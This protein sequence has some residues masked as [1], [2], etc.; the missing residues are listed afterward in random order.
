M[1]SVHNQSEAADEYNESPNETSLL[2]NSAYRSSKGGQSSMILPKR[3][4]SVRQPAAMDA[5]IISSI[6]PKHVHVGPGR[7]TTVTADLIEWMKEVDLREA[8]GC[9]VSSGPPRH[10]PESV[11]LNGAKV[12]VNPGGNLFIRGM[13]RIGIILHL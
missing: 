5:I 3:K 11:I 1:I 12:Q 13:H 2:Y 7:H 8:P 9:S 4:Q 6:P 10:I